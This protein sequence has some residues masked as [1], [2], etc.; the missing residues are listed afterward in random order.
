M[1]KREA[2]EAR[3]A[4]FVLSQMIDEQYMTET[5]CKENLDKLADFINKVDDEAEV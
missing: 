4:L 1:T 5:R 2:R 3:Q